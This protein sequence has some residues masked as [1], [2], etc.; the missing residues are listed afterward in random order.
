MQKKKN[1]LHNIIMLPMLALKKFRIGTTKKIPDRDREDIVQEIVLALINKK[2]EKEELMW[3]IAKEKATQYWRRG[4]IEDRNYKNILLSRYYYH[5]NPRSGQTTI[6][7]K[8]TDS[9]EEFF[10]FD[11]IDEFDEDLVLD[12]IILESFPATIKRIIE[13]RLQ[14][15]SLQD[16]ERAKLS[17]Y[18]RKHQEA[19]LA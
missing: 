11:L 2:A 6:V 5:Y 4:R 15:Y 7:S 17:Y 8:Y 10:E 19:Y 13:K 1:S 14:G 3:L 16:N 12:R 9:E 18:L